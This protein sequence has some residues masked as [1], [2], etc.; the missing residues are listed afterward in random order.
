[1]RSTC[2]VVLVILDGFGYTD[3]KTYNAIAAA[4]TPHLTTWITQYPHAYIHA[5]GASV[6]LLPGTVGNS[7]VGH[8]PMGAGR[9]VAQPA[10]IIHKAIIDGTFFDNQRMLHAFAELKKTGGRLHIMGLVSDGGVHSTL[11]L[12]SAVINAAASAG[13]VHIIVH[14]FLDGR[15][16]DPQSAK[17]Y[18]TQLETT[19]AQYK[20]V[21]LG[22][23]HGRFYAMD[24]D[25]N[26][27]R[28]YKAYQVLTESSTLAFDNWRSVLTHFYAQNITDEF[29]P[30]TQLSHDAVVRDLDGIFF[31]N[32]R[33]DRARELTTCFVDRAQVP[34]VTQN[35]SLACFITPVRYGAGGHTTALFDRSPIYNTLKDVLAQHHKTMVSIAETE[36]YAHV[37][38]FF[39]GQHEE[40]VP[41]EMRFL[42]PSVKVQNYIEYPAMSAPAITQAAVHALM[43]HQADFY[44]INYANADMVG[45]SGNFEATVKAVEC[46]DEQLGI[47]Y[48][49][50][51]QK[52]GGTLIITADHG[53]AESMHDEKTGQPYTRHTNNKVPFIVISPAKESNVNKLPTQLSEIAPFILQSM[54]ID[55]PDEMKHKGGVG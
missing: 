35:L 47:L 8:L 43:R 17:Q 38:Y 50:V 52:M 37:T 29:I 55:V 31:T 1:M 24:R 12:M 46:L 44:L 27:D 53:K 9:V 28:I 45:H 2:P 10:L 30:P 22:S 3:T 11:E 49:H 7:E 39:N 48:D 51:V 23:I 16:V 21:E 6:G 40:P 32:Y 14:A 15:D 5:S 54:A 25:S 18:L 42:I 13:I 20:H 34:F 19:I 33:P 26:W 36:K 4:S 41:G